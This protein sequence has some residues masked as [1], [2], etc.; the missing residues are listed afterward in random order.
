VTRCELEVS[1]ASYRY[2]GRQ[3]ASRI[4][5]LCLR[6][7]FEFRMMQTDPNWTN[8]LWDSEA[9]RVCSNTKGLNGQL[10]LTLGLGVPC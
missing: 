1:G 9:K 3:I 6:E 8:F 10:K 5:E 4:I 7:L 2:R